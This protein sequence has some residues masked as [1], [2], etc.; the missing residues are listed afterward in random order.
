MKRQSK[1]SDVNYY[2]LDHI[3]TKKCDQCGKEFD[4]TAEWGYKVSYK[5]LSRSPKKIFCTYS[6]MRAYERAHPVG[7]RG[8]ALAE[9]MHNKNKKKKEA[10]T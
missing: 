9:A 10:A 4:C 1:M 5:G 3:K 6:C 7:R 2:G 8:E